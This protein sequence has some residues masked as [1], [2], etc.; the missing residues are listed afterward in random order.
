MPWEA[1]H[2]T[3]ALSCCCGARPQCR[4]SRYSTAPSCSTITHAP[5]IISPS[6]ST[7]SRRSS[8]PPIL[9][10]SQPSPSHLPPPHTGVRNLTI[11]HNNCVELVRTLHGVFEACD[12]GPDATGD[13]LKEVFELRRIVL[14]TATMTC[15]RLRLPR[16][17]R[18]MDYGSVAVEAVKGLDKLV[19]GL[20]TKSDSTALCALGAES[21]GYEWA[22]T[23]LTVLSCRLRNLWIRWEDKK[24]DGSRV[25]LNIQMMR[26]IDNNIAKVQD[27]AYALQELNDTPTPF[28]YV[29][30]LKIFIYI[31]LYSVPF[32]IFDKLDWLVIPVMF[33]L[34]LGYARTHTTTAGG[35]DYRV[36]GCVCLIKGRSSGGCPYVQ[37]GSRD[38]MFFNLLTSPT[39]HPSPVSLLPFQPLPTL[40]LPLYPPPSPNPSFPYIH[41]SHTLHGRYI[42]LDVIANELDDPFGPDPNDLKL[43]HTLAS[44]GAIMH[45]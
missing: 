17:K 42:G 23:L 6:T 24:A 45:D 20:M 37:R 10:S 8:H 26:D 34:T 2:T 29:Q 7:P 9:P 32:I 15:R 39:F 25:M 4:S 14:L 28:P 35:W 27:A 21:T 40:P 5:A 33:L 1:A 22:P 19:P 12:A 41:V 16:R 3:D 30:L 11:L 43:E 36:P 18:G 31:F 13:R 38:T 44:I